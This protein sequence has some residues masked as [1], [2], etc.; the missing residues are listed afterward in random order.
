MTYTHELRDAAGFEKQQEML[1]KLSIEQPTIVDV[2][3]NVGQSIAGYLELFPTARIHSFEPHPDAFSKMKARYAGREQIRIEPLALGNTCGDATFY[4]AELSEVSS[5]LPPD[6]MVV[7]RSSNSTYS[8]RQIQVPVDTLDRYCGRT[9]T[10]HIHI[11]KI[12]VQGA[13]LDVLEGAKGLLSEGQV[14]LLFVEVMFAANYSG[15]SYLDDI[16]RL[17]KAHEYVLW[18]LFPFLHTRAGRLWTGNAIFASPTA[19]Q[20]LDPD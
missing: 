11:L 17:L 10:E 14:D 6:P 9:Q 18:D 7:A 1:A 19:A 2:G 13:E 8:N 16:W 4:A 3:G 20:T 5:L 15:Q 12:D